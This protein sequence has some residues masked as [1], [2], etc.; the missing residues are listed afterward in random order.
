MV[1][2]HNIFFFLIYISIFRLSSDSHCLWSGKDLFCV[3]SNHGTFQPIYS[4]ST[5]DHPAATVCL[6][7]LHVWR[8]LFFFDRQGQN[9]TKSK[10]VDQ[11]K[12][13]QLISDHFKLLRITGWWEIEQLQN[14]SGLS[15]IIS[16]LSN[17]TGSCLWNLCLKA[18]PSPLNAYN[19]RQLVFF[20]RFLAC[21]AALVAISKTSLT[22]SLVF[23]EHSW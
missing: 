12:V 9:G 22:P 17:I 4:R 23:A 14:V 15:P 2:I 20:P 10:C 16:P 21:S 6:M 18:A 19:R 8:V 13:F 5:S 7:D 1:V 3:H 11:W